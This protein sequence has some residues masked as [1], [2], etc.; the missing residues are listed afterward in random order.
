[1]IRDHGYG[2]QRFFYLIQDFEPNFYAWGPEYADAMASYG[3]D[4]EPIFNT[5]L[6][7]DYFIEQGFGFAGPDTL[8]FHPAIDIARYADRPRPDRDGPRRL[9]LYGRPEVARNMYPTAI[10]ALS[11][12]IETEKLGPEDI[13]PVSIGLSHAPVSL[14]RGVVLDSLGKLPWEAYPDYLLGTDLGLSLMY[15]PH[16]SHPPIEMAASG[17]RVVTNRFGPKDLSRLS[18]AILSA[19]PAAPALAA[20][21]S[22]AWAMPPV[23]A[24]ERRIDLGAL[25]D[26][27]DAMTDRLSDRI[28]PLLA[29]AAA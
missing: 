14:P 6:L 12:F 24:A 25:G 27:L 4:F 11:A 8:A 1:M 3:L 23:T 5:T 19:E 7:R 26:P 29:E 2:A 10:E 15:S 20:A 21:L 9:A 17:V 22:R 16:P 18:P 28:A 13:A